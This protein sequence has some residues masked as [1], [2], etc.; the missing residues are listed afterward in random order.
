VRRQVRL[1]N[2][3]E[4][5][6]AACVTRGSIGD[7]NYIKTYVLAM[8]RVTRVTHPPGHS[9][10]A[11]IACQREPIHFDQTATLGLA[12]LVSNICVS[13]G[14]ISVLAR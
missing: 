8:W 1:L 10:R 2:E 13:L 5:D 14:V 12:R 7:A 9:L 6:P 11:L 4:E 3:P